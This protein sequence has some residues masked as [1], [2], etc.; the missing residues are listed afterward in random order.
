MVVDGDILHIGAS[1]RRLLYLPSFVPYQVVMTITFAWTAYYI[2][3]ILSCSGIVSILF[4]GIT[5]SHYTYNNLS[6]DA[7][8]FTRKMY[9]FLAL[10]AET[11]VF[12]YLGFS[13]FAFPV[14]EDVS[15]ATYFLALVAC[16][17]GR[18]AHV[19]PIS[20]L[21]NR[22][23]QNKPSKKV[24][25]LLFDSVSARLIGCVFCVC[26]LPPSGTFSRRACTWRC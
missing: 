9:K 1:D 22:A 18:A 21:W 15:V 8:N 13:W 10:L 26:R 2:A 3:E 6:E 16:I 23:V 4:C 20:F 11:F 24:H 12:V 7:Q 5:M 17:I 25:C 19:Y 14:F